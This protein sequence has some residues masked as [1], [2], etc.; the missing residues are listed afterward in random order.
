MAD[1][2]PLYFSIGIKITI[3]AYQNKKQTYNWLNILHVT[4]TIP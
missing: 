1:K 4:F 2:P 3:I